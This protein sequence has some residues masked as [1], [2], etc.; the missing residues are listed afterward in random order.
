MTG[1]FFVPS[2]IYMLIPSID[3]VNIRTRNKN[4][5]IDADPKVTKKCCASLIESDFVIALEQHNSQPKWSQLRFKWISAVTYYSRKDS[6]NLCV[7][8]QQSIYQYLLLPQYFRFFLST[9]TQY[10][11]FTLIRGPFVED[12]YQCVTYE[13]YTAAWQEQFYTTF[14]LVFMFIIPLGILLVTYISTFKT[15]SGE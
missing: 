2:E 9:L 12:F 7:N 6:G 13:F 14:T 3:P 4:K 5:L 1:S 10:Y 8:K 15:I 11:I